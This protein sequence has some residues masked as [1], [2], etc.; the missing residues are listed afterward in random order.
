EQGLYGFSWHG[1]AC[2]GAG[3][4]R[5]RADPTC[6]RRLDFADAGRHP[7]EDICMENRFLGQAWHRRLALR[8]D[9][10]RDESGH[11]NDEW[12]KIC[13]VE[14]ARLARRNGLMPSS[15]LILTNPTTSPPFGSTAWTHTLLNPFFSSGYWAIMAL[16][17]LRASACVALKSAVLGTEYFIVRSKFLSLRK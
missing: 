17:R 7:K 16:A 15:Y 2:R 8:P 1:R 10:G 6:R 9:A 14:V 3:S 11:H 5:R 12:R 13:A 4:D